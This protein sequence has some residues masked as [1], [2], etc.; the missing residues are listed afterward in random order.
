MITDTDIQK[1]LGA[2]MKIFATKEDLKSFATKEDLRI[3]EE[4]IDKQMVLFRDDILEH[5]D[6]IYKEVLANRDE[7]VMH[8][9]SHLR[10]Q[11]V[12]DNHEKKIKKLETAFSAP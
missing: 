10:M 6:K 1:I 9:G 8:Q 5:L 12:L 4:K 2:F 7:R 3:L 11:E